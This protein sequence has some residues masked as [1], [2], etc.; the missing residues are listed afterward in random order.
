MNRE[1]LLLNRIKESGFNKKDFAARVDMPYST[2]LSIL[3]NV[4]G[5]S[6]D[7]VIKICN[8]LDISI[9]ILN[10]YANGDHD[11]LI[12]S[13]YRK[14]NSLGKAKVAEYLEVLSES[15]KYTANTPTISDDI[16]KELK[17]DATILSKQ[18]QRW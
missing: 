2:L 13:Q 5:A 1:E 3:K 14:L 15:E 8:G 4:G 16:T 11:S 17:Q 6:L 9:E 10:P 12:D 18:K 7:N